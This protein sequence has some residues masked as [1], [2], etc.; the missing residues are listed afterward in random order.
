MRHLLA[1]GSGWHLAAQ[2]PTERVPLALEQVL[3]LQPPV[4][5]LITHA[6]RGS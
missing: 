6:D 5:G 4:P 2:M 3:A 1:P